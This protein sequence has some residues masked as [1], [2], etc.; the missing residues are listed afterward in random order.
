[1]IVGGLITHHL[2]TTAQMTTERRKMK[3]PVVQTWC[4]IKGVANE[5]FVGR[6]TANAAD[7]EQTPRGDWTNHLHSPKIV[8]RRRNP[9]Y[10]SPRLSQNMKNTNQAKSKKSFMDV[11]P[12]TEPVLW[13]D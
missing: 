3:N 1:M 6:A 8:G 7:L 11:Q 5:E 12:G 9:L 4:P 2:R 10:Q 13:T